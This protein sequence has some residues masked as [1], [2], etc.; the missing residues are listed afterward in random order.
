M[1]T[2]PPRTVTHMH[3]SYPQ[4]PLGF[5]PG[6]GPCC[7]T[8]H[9]TELA[10][11]HLH[12]GVKEHWTGYHTSPPELDFRSCQMTQ[13][14]PASSANLICQ[15]KKRS[16]RESLM[17]LKGH[18]QKQVLKFCHT[19]PVH[20]KYVLKALKICMCFEPAPL[21]LGEENKYAKEIYCEAYNSKKLRKTQM[22]LVGGEI[23]YST[24]LQWN[25]MQPLTAMRQKRHETVL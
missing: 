24:S 23:H 9:F 18:R 4:G 17:W 1:S 11:P 16:G 12:V 15:E 22:F 6:S 8:Q 7:T 20:F 2:F 5:L 13:C 3:P 25:T 10:V 19:E 14:L 21:L